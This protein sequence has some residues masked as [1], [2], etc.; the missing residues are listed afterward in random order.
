MQQDHEARSGDQN[1]Y[2]SLPFDHSMLSPLLWMGWWLWYS[3]NAGR[4]GSSAVALL[5]SP[6]NLS[7]ALYTQG[8]PHQVFNWVF[9]LHPS[10]VSLLLHTSM[11]WLTAP[12]L[13]LGWA[14]LFLSFGLYAVFELLCGGFYKYQN[15]RQRYKAEWALVTGASSGE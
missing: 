11:S 1:D 14:V 3:C 4:S 9:D 13:W 2:G 12:V 8:S 5:T 6:S 10:L 7:I 15:L